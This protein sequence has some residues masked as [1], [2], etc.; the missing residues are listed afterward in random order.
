MQY[1]T[2]L[3]QCKVLYTLH[4]QYYGSSLD[5]KNSS[6]KSE[7]CVFKYIPNANLNCAFS[8]L[9]FVTE[10]PQLLQAKVSGMSSQCSVCWNMQVQWVANEGQYQAYNP[11]HWKWWATVNQ[12]DTIHNIFHIRLVLIQANSS[13]VIYCD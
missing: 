6:I 13:N 12:G 4:I 10:I 1:V 9:K 7:V 8:C 3:L 5:I 2:E 11:H